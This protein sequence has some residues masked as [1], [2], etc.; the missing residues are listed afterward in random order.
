[1]IFSKCMFSGFFPPKFE[2]Q[3]LPHV[4]SSGRQRCK[5]AVRCWISLTCA[6]MSGARQL[7][8]N[9]GARIFAFFF[10]WAFFV[11]LLT[12]SN[13]WGSDSTAVFLFPSLLF[14]FLTFSHQGTLD[15]V[16]WYIKYCS[17]F[18]AFRFF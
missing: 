4:S 10:F 12:D 7:L 14:C 5:L 1:M 9:S 13:K 8:C 3:K 15:L 2:G 6:G 11:L 17:S 18:F 16:R